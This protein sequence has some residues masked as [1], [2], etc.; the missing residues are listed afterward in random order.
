MTWVDWQQNFDL[1]KQD[2]CVEEADGLTNCCSTRE[3]YYKAYMTSYRERMEESLR[4]CAKDCPNK[5]ECVVL[6]GHSQG[7]AIAAVAGLAL[8]DMNPY[9]ITFGQ[10]ATIDAPCDMITSER[11]YRF[12][13]TKASEKVGIAYDPVPFVPGLGAD[14]FGHLILLSE[15]PTGVAYIGLDVQD[16]FG[17]LNTLGFESHSMVAPEGGEFPGYINRLDALVAH[18]NATFPIRAGGYA[19]GTLCS[20]GKECMSGKCAAETIFTFNRCV[21]VE[22]DSDDD[23]ET[24][25]CDSGACIPKEGSCMPCDEDTDCAGGKCLLF[26]CSG[27][28]GLMDDQCICKWD[29]D[30]QSHRCELFSTGMCEAQL[31]VGAYCNEDSDCKSDYCSWKFRCEDTTRAIAME[32]VQEQEIKNK[33]NSKGLI[34]GIVAIGA[35]VLYFAARQYNK[36][37]KGYTEIPTEM[38]V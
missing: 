6:T 29:S 8:A 15:D 12:V 5:D 7:G 34:V 11:W 16:S 23:C 24:G 30:C 37:R 19:A 2:V 18:A 26:K 22:C 13:N 32:I 20:Q 28:D 3:G 14:D 27:K 10:P 17:P 1:G 9:V 33:K 21:G 35:V 25:R 38:S 36:Y 31:A 4:E